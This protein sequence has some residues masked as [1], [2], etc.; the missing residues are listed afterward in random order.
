[1]TAK[2]LIELL[3]VEAK[4]YRKDALKSIIRNAH[5]N[6]LTRYDILKLEKHPD[7]SNTAIDAV[8]VDFINFV[9]KNQGRDWGLRVKRLKEVP[10]AMNLTSEVMS[11]TRKYVRSKKGRKEIKKILSET[12]AALN[13]L[14]EARKVYEKSLNQK[15]TI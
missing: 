10:K 1:M 2:E 3:E 9:A 7:L 14:K 6:E 5:T 15:I 8:L 4:K 11:A 13:K 12:E